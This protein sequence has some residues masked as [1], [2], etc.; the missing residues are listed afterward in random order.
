MSNDSAPLTKLDLARYYESVGERLLSHIKGRPCSIIRAPDGID[1]ERFFQ[2]HAMRGTSNLMTLKKV[3]GDRKPYVQVDRIEALAA[4]AQI[5]AVE[6][7]PWNCQPDHPE[8]PGR[9]V[10]D[11]DPAPDVDFDE[12]IVAAKEMKRAARN[13]WPGHVLQDD[14]RQ[15]V[16]CRHAARAAE[17]GQP[18]LAGSQGVRAGRVCADG[19]GQPR[20]LCP[21]HV[22]EAARR[23][24]LPRL[25]AQR[26]HVDRSRPVFTAR[27]RRRDRIDAA[28]MVAGQ[29]GLDPRRYTMRTAPALIAR[30]TAWAEY[31][32]SERPLEPAIR[33]VVKAGGG[34]P[35]R[36]TGGRSRRRESQHAHTPG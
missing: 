27:A 20:S 9:L 26:S 5:A 36:S 31:C 14:G 3:S 19:E 33:K 28:H 12:V 8:I 24:H 2:R 10:F 13:A 7:H 21:Q 29:G 23:A 25:P 17:K 30:S 15:R 32:D 11:L 22:E 6:L 4:L 1:G 16:A 35:M 18:P 34:R